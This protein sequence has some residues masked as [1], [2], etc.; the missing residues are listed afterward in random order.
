VSELPKGW[1]ELDCGSTFEQISTSNIKVKSKDTLQEGAFPVVDQGASFIAG[2]VNDEDKVIEVDSPICV[3]GDHTRIIKW[4]DFNF[5][6]GADGTKVLVPCEYLYPRYF[7]H[8]L[9][10]LDV[11]DRGYSRHFKYLKESI[12]RIAP[13]SEQVRI[14]NK[15]DSILAKVDNVQIS[16]KK[17]PVILK[18]FRQSVLAAATSGELTR[19]WRSLNEGATSADLVAE[20]L[21]LVKD[22]KAKKLADKPFLKD[23]IKLSIPDSW[24]WARLSGI[25]D[26]ASGVAKGSKRSGEEV[27]VPYLRVANVQRGYLDLAIVKE[28]TVVKSL[29]E[30]LYL[31]VGDVLFNEG[32]DL[33]KLGRGWIWEG[34]VDKCIHQNHVFRARVLS[35]KLQP[36]YLS[37]FGNEGA[38]EY[39]LRGGTQTVNL[40]NLNKT[41]LSSLPVPVPPEEEQKEIVRRV[42]ELFLLASAV[43]R[44]YSDVKNRS[45]RLTQS[46]LC[47]AFRGEL[48]PQDHEDEPAEILL[49]KI[50]AAKLKPKVKSKK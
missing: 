32:G 48:V 1:V 15:L 8:Q 9:K 22:K 44:H 19:E 43:E 13:L 4:V 28:I 40:A 3:F 26:I 39:F 34:Q 16:L 33:D 29:A 27:V 12:F 25:T 45:D 46:V 10:S 17:I 21:G 42:D 14:A 18:R 47:K 49:E 31:E 41:T 5:V 7:Y 6:P 36:K 11:I 23:E 38:K 30:R 24:R 37:Y 50:M 35:E 2:Y 20:L